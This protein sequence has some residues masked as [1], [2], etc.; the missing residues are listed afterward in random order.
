MARKYFGTD[1]I[2][3]RVGEGAI[4]PEFVLK[5]GWAAGK[6][7]AESGRSFYPQLVKRRVSFDIPG[8][9]RTVIQGS[10]KL[11]WT[12]GADDASAWELYDLREDPDGVRNLY[13]PDDPRVA[14]LQDQLFQWLRSAPETSAEERQDELSE[15]DRQ[16]LRSL[17]S[18]Q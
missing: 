10:E 17:G 7:F 18:L 9:F 2:R 4:T 13:R 14:P 11:V 8:R 15:E 12:P 5:L 6:V 16:R 3:G 1:G